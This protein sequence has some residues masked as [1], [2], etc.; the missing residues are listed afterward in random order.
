MHKVCTVYINSYILRDI[1]EKSAL[2]E[3]PIL[4]NYIKRQAPATTKPEINELNR[5]TFRE[6][7]AIFMPATY[8]GLVIGR[9]NQNQHIKRMI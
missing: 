9:Q 2:M 6:G 3:R 1:R 8:M 7:S 5:S 4:S